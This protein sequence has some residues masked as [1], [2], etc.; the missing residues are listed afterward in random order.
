MLLNVVL[1]PEAPAVTPLIVAVPPCGLYVW[2]RATLA[3]GA[4]VAVGVPDDWKTKLP[5][6]MVGSGSTTTAAFAGVVAGMGTW[7]VPAEVMLP[8]VARAV[9][10]NSRNHRSPEGG[11]SEGEGPDL[12]LLDAA[13]RD[14]EVSFF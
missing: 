12:T 11:S 1:A 4:K 3:P 9:L 5:P 7:S 10:D 6:A 13:R 14:G 8:T 2:L